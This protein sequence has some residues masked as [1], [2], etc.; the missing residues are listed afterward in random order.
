MIIG[1]KLPLNY[2]YN[3]DIHPS[4]SQIRLFVDDKALMN[5]FHHSL[6]N[7]NKGEKDIDLIDGHAVLYATVVLFQRHLIVVQGES[8]T[9]Q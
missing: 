3:V 8:D 6:N 1:D 4:V 9:V 7:V 5:N 2:D